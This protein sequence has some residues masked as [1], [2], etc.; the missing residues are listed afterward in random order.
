MYEEINIEGVGSFVAYYEKCNDVLREKY[1]HATRKSE[2]SVIDPNDP[3]T[4]TD[5]MIDDIL[6]ELSLEENEGGYDF[7][8]GF[9]DTEDYE[10]L[11]NIK[12]TTSVDQINKLVARLK[13]YK[14][15]MQQKKAEKEAKYAAEKAAKKA[16]KEAADKAVDSEN[17]KLEEELLKSGLFKF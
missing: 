9:M 14:S 12:A 5:N 8:C 16:A 13:K 10:N 11:E 17:K 6:F 4:F 3:N 7:G 1:F 2:S 15:D